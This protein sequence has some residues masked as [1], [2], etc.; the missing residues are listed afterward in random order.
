MVLLSK[1]VAMTRK[2]QGGGVQVGGCCDQL[3]GSFNMGSPAGSKGRALALLS[4][5]ENIE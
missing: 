2:W 1:E 4:L 3:L 5:L